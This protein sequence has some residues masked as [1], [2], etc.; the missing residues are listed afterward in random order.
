MKRFIVVLAV[1]LTFGVGGED[2]QR[3]MRAIIIVFAVYL[4][5]QGFFSQTTT[6]T[7]EASAAVKSGSFTSQLIDG[8][9]YLTPTVKG[10]ISSTALLVG[11]GF[12]AMSLDLDLKA[13]DEEEEQALFEAAYEAKQK[14]MDEDAKRKDLT[15][16]YK[17]YNIG[18]NFDKMFAQPYDL[19]EQKRKEKYDKL[20]EYKHFN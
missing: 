20:Y 10:Y 5:Y 14:E 12:Q 4:A 16:K 9:Y 8:V 15:L 1:L 2:E 11:S 7:A 18:A 17:N 6:S 19:K 3:I 13:D